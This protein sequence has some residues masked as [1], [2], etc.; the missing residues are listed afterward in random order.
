MRNIL[1]FIIRLYDEIFLS[2]Y[3]NP[4]YCNMTYANCQVLAE[5]GMKIFLRGMK[6]FV[7]I[8]TVLLI[9]L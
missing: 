3:R 8:V 1:C 2:V 4:L 9:L 7:R 6:S 5:G